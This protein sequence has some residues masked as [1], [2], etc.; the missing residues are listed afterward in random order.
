MSFMMALL[1]VPI[2]FIVVLLIGAIPLYFATKLF[3]VENSSMLKAILV[4][5]IAG[6]ISGVVSGILAAIGTIIPVLPHILGV[7][8]PLGIYMIVI[9]QAYKTPVLT[10]FL[11]ALIEYVVAM[12][13]AVITLVMILIPLGIGAAFLVG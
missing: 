11:I 3:G 4:N 10:S 9:M 1:L 7:I 5:L 2:V 12:V 13:L 6:A 8:A